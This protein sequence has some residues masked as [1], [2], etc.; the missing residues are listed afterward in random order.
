[1]TDDDRLRA[2]PDRIGESRTLVQEAEP[3]AV[4]EL[5]EIKMRDRRSC[6]AIDHNRL[7]SVLIGMHTDARET[8]PLDE[9][10][11]RQH[12]TLGVADVNEIV[13]AVVDHKTDKSEG[14]RDRAN[15]S[16]RP[17]AEVEPDGGGSRE[18]DGG[19]EDR[20]GAAESV[21]Q[22]DQQQAARRGPEKIEKIN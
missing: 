1:C 20:I 13:L 16:V 14:E 4:G 19:G 18:A 15:A 6:I 17:P 8:V 10:L 12:R 11:L 21:Q 7:S 22:R 2:R 9:L 5:L 3:L